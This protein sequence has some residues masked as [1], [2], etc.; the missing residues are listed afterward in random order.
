MGMGRAGG[1]APA[2]W[3]R[4]RVRR[5]LTRV[6]HKTACCLSERVRLCWNCPWS[7]PCTSGRH[8][9]DVVPPSELA[10]C[11]LSRCCPLPP[12]SRRT[13][14]PCPFLV[15]SRFL[16]AENPTHTA[17][18]YD[19]RTASCCAA[20]ARLRADR[21]WVGVLSGCAA[22]TELLRVL[23]LGSKGLRHRLAPPARP[24]RYCRVTQSQSACLATQ[25]RR[26]R[27]GLGWRR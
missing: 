18:L 16:S 11:R 8:C 15:V 13:P 20:R 9:W 22:G 26:R 4:L 17:T 1:T 5:S 21:C 27:L 12:P 3:S 2:R 23:W 19:E 7:W 14:N 10:A 24:R 6:S 25:S